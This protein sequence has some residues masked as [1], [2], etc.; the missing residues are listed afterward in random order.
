MVRHP[1]EFMQ[2][3]K[4]ALTPGKMLEV[5][6]YVYLPENKSILYFR[7]SGEVISDADFESLQKIPAQNLLIPRSEH[8]QY[9]T[10]L[11]REMNAHIS[12]GSF[13][14]PA[15]KQGAGAVLGSIT[16]TSAGDEKPS[17]E[18]AREVL[19]TIP[20][21]VENMIR[22]FKKTPSLE[23]YEAILNSIQAS[24]DILED[25]HRKVSALA[26]LI[27]LTVVD[28]PN[29][30]D[31]IHLGIAGLVHDLGLRD[32]TKILL[33]RHVI[34]DEEFTAS[35]KIIYMRH[36][37][38]SSAALHLKKIVVSPR[39]HDIISDHHENWDGSGFKALSGTAINFSA[40]ILRLTDDIV[41]VISHPKNHLGF[42]EALAHV[43][44]RGTQFN[45]P[46]YDP[47]IVNKLGESLGIGEPIQ[48]G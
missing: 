7:R 13:D 20:K 47:Q 8:K 46:H 21:L 27:L 22:Q 4:G 39:V 29:N 41:G 18:V 11:S 1:S 15:V 23:T 2:V 17:G 31:L 26:V 45:A 28:Q 24:D 36:P 38:L 3:Q 35:E 32:S 16:A 9:L 5:N 34:G 48:Y 44:A 40:R 6:L 10:M 33:E 37:E 12:S 30:D 42:R 43:S 25:H 14:A 19:S